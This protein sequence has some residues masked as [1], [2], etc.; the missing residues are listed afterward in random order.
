[1]EILGLE[2]VRNFFEYVRC[3]REN[4]LLLFFMNVIMNVIKFYVKGIVRKIGLSL[5][6]FIVFVIF[7]GL[8]L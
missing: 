3:F 5:E 8:F 4:I 6:F 7:V 2:W 1:M